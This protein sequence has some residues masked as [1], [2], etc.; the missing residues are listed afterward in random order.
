MGVMKK[1]VVILIGIVSLWVSSIVF[2]GDALATTGKKT[3]SWYSPDRENF[4]RLIVAASGVVVGVPL[5]AFLLKKALKE[6][7]KGGA[8]GKFIGL[9][10]G[11]A[12]AGLLSA[13]AGGRLAQELDDAYLYTRSIKKI[14][15]LCSNRELMSKNLHHI[16][17]DFDRRSI[18]WGKYLFSRARVTE[19]FARSRD[20]VVNHLRPAFAQQLCRE[21]AFLFEK[22]ELLPLRHFNVKDSG[23]ISADKRSELQQN[24][25]QARGILDGLQNQVDA[26]EEIESRLMHEGGACIP[27]HFS[28]GMIISTIDA[29]REVLMQ[30]EQAISSS[31]NK[32]LASQS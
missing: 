32:D 28:H 17:E 10:V 2:C 24:I 3:V 22:P 20:Y 25:V 12:A 15:S 19:V 9:T 14:M 30:V 16:Q 26:L 1:I 6:A 18:G 27:N 11:A 31:S 7:K 4:G 29:Q 8:K 5:F 23:I 13:V 21:A